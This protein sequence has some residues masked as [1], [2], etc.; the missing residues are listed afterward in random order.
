MPN[1]E[2]NERRWKSPKDPSRSESR[3]NTDFP[4]LLTAL[5]GLSCSMV[6]MSLNAEWLTPLPTKITTLHRQ[7]LPN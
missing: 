1:P 7:V 6:F 3:S 2:E 5:L 4:E